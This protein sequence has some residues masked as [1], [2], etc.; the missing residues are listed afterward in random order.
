MDGKIEQRVCIKFCVKLGKSATETLEM[1]HETFGEHCLS[2]TAVF[3][4]RSR[5]KAGRVSVEDG[6]CSGRP[7]TSNTTENVENIRQLINE[8]CRRTIHKL[9]YTVGISCGVCQEILMEN[10]NMR[11]IAAKFVLRLLTND[12]KQQRVKFCLEL[13]EKAS[14]DLT[15]ISR[16]D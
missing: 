13:R 10:L 11:R 7:S 12:Q 1:L 3:K 8:D 4:W 2:R 9:A 6:E 15:F 5:F 14:E 16:K